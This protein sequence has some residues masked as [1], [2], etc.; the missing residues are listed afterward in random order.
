MWIFGFLHPLCDLHKS[1]ISSLPH[2]AL[3]N[4]RS[5]DTVGCLSVS[6]LF[7][8]NPLLLCVQATALRLTTNN[9][10]DIDY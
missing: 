6:V 1:V 9:S 10:I 4:D 2:S 5:L 3:T 7:G 8:Q